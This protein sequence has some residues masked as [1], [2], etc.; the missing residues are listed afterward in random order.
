VAFCPLGR[1]FLTGKVNRAEEYLEDDFRRGNPRYQGENYDA[2][3]RAAAIVH[4]IATAK[5]ATPGQIALAGLFTKGDE[6]VPI[7]GA[8][9]TKRWMRCTSESHDAR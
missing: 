8:T 5:H 4:D 2:N 9:S 6:I 3:L 1:V 7:P